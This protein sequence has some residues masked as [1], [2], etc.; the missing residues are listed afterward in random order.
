MGYFSGKNILICGG[1]GFIGIN[2]LNRI[3]DSGAKIRATLNDKPAVVNHDSIEY[4]KG[5]LRDA[6]FCSSIV[7][8]IDYVFML[9]ANSS[10][11][12]VMSKTPLVHVTPNVIMNALMLDAAYSAGVKKFLFVSSN[13]VYPNTNY[14]VK[15]DEMLSGEPYDTYFCVGW[16]KRFSEIMCEMY[17]KKIKNPMKTVVIRPGNA[18][19]E[20]DKFE[21]ETSKVIAATIRKVVER[22]A[23]IEVWGDGKDIKDFIYI[24]DLVEGMLLAMEKVEDYTPLNIASGKPVTIRE[25]LSTSLKIEG[26]EDAKVVYNVSKPSMIPLRLIDVSKAKVVLGFEA[27]TPLYE[28]L[29]RTIDWYKATL[30]RGE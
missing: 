21:W 25:V 20:Y 22:Q 27:K 12:A 4:V 17:A 24:G 1:A 18:Y 8:G 23:P 3:K 29:K 6:E 26:Y 19:G 11:A 30:K 2:L 28:G 7:K 10:G 13:T 16:M 15:E 5:N 9:A 14:P